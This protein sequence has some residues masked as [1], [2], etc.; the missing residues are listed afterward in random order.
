MA[1]AARKDGLRPSILDRLI[2]DNPG[3]AVQWRAGDAPDRQRYMSLN[4]YRNN[5]RRDLAWL[6]NTANLTS[7]LNLEEFP[8]VESSV[9]NFGVPDISGLTSSTVNANEL[10][11]SVKNIILRFEP[12]FVQK[13]LR[14]H[15]EINPDQLNNNALSFVIDG[16]L[17][18][19]PASVPIS[20]RTE[21]DLETGQV[22]ISE[23]TR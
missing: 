5:V 8:E 17:R 1:R 3:D 2:D 15:V 14:I 12:R 18:A 4:E 9:V 16:E 6:M 21:L 20:L 10:Q 23:N 22:A 13:S 11:K 19:D 7:V